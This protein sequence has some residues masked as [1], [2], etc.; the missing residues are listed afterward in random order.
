MSTPFLTHARTTGTR[1]PFGVTDAM[2]RADQRRSRL[3]S[4][5]RRLPPS[6]DRWVER[7]RQRLL[8]DFVFAT[9]QELAR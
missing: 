5:L 7:R 9:D 4:E 3:Q 8:A 6:R 1:D 2:F